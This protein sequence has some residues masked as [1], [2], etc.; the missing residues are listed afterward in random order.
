MCADYIGYVHNVE[1]VK[2]YGG[3]TTNKVKLR[4]IGIRNLK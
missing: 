4:N 3:V 2:E 1:Q